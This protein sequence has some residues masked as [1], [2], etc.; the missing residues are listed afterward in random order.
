MGSLCSDYL[1][2]FA[3]AETMSSRIPIIGVRK[4]DRRKKPM[5][6]RGILLP[7]IPISMHTN[8]YINK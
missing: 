3:G 6:P 8:A 4:K 7:I 5:K 1:H 2:G